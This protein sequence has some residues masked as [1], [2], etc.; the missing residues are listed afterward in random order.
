[1][2]PDCCVKIQNILWRLGCWWTFG[3]WLDPE[4][5]VWWHHSVTFLG[6]DGNCRQG[7]VEGSE[8]WGGDFGD[9]SGSYPLP[10]GLFPCLHPN[11]HEVSSFSPSLS[12]QW[13]FNLTRDLKATEPH[14]RGLKPKNKSFLELFLSSV[15]SK[16]QKAPQ[17]TMERNLLGEVLCIIKLTA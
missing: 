2:F 9:E 5:I 1:M 4:L 12:F 10:L 6:S 11:F 8:S 7:P 16:P 15:L 3:M 14:N 13:S 17:H